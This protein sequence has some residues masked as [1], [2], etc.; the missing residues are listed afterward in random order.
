M[1]FLKKNMVFFRKDGF[2]LEIWSVIRNIFVHLFNKEF[3]SKM[4]SK[5][6]Q[7]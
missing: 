2:A 1:V 4:V 6:A 7:N 5:M 3:L